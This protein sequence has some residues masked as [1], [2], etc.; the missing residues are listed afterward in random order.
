LAHP[1]AQRWVGVASTLRH[2]R[3]PAALDRVFS[4]VI[5]G[6]GRKVNVALAVAGKP[7]AQTTVNCLTLMAV[8]IVKFLTVT[9]GHVGYA[10]IPSA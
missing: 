1:A 3:R 7:V 10:W 4:Q 2:I 9:N 6:L 8:V 5:D